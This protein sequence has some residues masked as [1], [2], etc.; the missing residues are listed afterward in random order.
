[1]RGQL[2]LITPACLVRQTGF[3]EYS[4]IYITL[5]PLL[6][7]T[8]Y[9]SLYQQISQACCCITVFLGEELLGEGTGFAISQDGAVFTAAHVVTCRMPIR[10]SDYKDPAIK[11]YAKFPGVPVLEYNVS[12]CGIHISVDSFTEVVQID[13]ALLFPAQPVQF[14]FAAFTI[15][16]PP[17]LGEEVFFAGYS[18]ELELPFRVDRLLKPETTGATG[19]FQA[20]QR[21]YRA[22]M[23]GPM[24]KRG[25]AG[26]V[27]RIGTVEAATNIEIECEVFYIDN[28]IH[29][30][31][32]GGPIVNRNGL[33]VGVIVQRAT[34][35]ASQS[36]DPNLLVPSGATV[37]L[38]LQT[39][40]AMYRRLSGA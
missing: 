14:P 13:Q 33:A 31:A 34:T 30:C 17:R 25:V 35:S 4:V 5:G 28:S 22:D 29:C 37:G 8:M 21:G 3:P 10:E 9:E 6:S 12:I 27:R 19:F 20:M 26:N 2:H 23:T 15:G 40:P 38:G 24:I 39:I 7:R 11:I 32:S 1:M 16:S 18:D 36:S